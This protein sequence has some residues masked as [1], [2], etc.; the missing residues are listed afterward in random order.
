M[1]RPSKWL[2]ETTAIRVPKFLS[3]SLT[4][5]ARLIEESFVQNPVENFLNDGYFVGGRVTNLYQKSQG[6]GIIDHLTPYMVYVVWI[7]KP[8]SLNW[9]E[10]G[11]TAYG[12]MFCTKY[13]IPVPNQEQKTA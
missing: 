3:E 13:L 2:T 4:D 8:E 6:E 1:S 9:K 10:I 11:A 5:Y 12:R 7:G